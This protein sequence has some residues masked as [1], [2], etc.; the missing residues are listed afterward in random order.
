MAFDVLI[1]TARE[2]LAKS[3]VKDSLV[4]YIPELYGCYHQ[5]LIYS[6]NHEL[7]QSDLKLLNLEKSKLVSV[8]YYA[9]REQSYDEFN[10]YLEKLNS[11]DYF[12]LYYI[13]KN[14]KQILDLEFYASYTKRELKRQYL[15]LCRQNHPDK[16]ISNDI[17]SNHMWSVQFHAI[18][19]AYKF[20]T[21]V[22]SEMVL[23][24]LR[25]IEK[26]DSEDLGIEKTGIIRFN[27]LK[28]ELIKKEFDVYISKALRDHQAKLLENFNIELKV[29][30][31]NFMQKSGEDIIKFSENI[32]AKL[33]EVNK[34]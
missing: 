3:K 6:L 29:M 16:N 23:E 31:N 25:I 17:I 26:L 24:S 20:L 32:Q 11:G 2:L 7:T 18:N 1:S 22:K 30:Y 15:I 8:L 27:K 10:C 21:S 5:L 33:A 34:I 19:S 13:I 28:E 12:A 14:I 9:Y 4:N